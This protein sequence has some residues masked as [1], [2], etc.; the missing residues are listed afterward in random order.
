MAVATGSCGSPTGSPGVRPVD[1]G[2]QLILR[3]SVGP[4]FSGMDIYVVADDSV[5]VRADVVGRPE[6]YE[7]PVL[8]ASDTSAVTVRSDGTASIR[9]AMGTLT[10]TAT[11]RARAAN[12]RPATLLT[13]GKFTP[14]CQ[15]YAAAGI[16]VAVRDSIAGV[17]VSGPGAMRL[18]ATNGVASDSLRATILVGSW[19]TA[20]ETP[21]MWTVS[22]DA[23]GYRPWRQAGVVVTK[24]LCHVRPIAVTAKLQR[25]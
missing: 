23:E 18:H 7:S 12:T 15:A 19:A 8:T 6:L 10:F 22:V 25:P 14:V 3:A 9:R 4:E 2:S 16:N 13:S 24:G 20:W 5:I 17:A 11:A 21:G 1:S